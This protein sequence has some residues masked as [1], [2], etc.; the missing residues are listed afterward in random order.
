MS[1]RERFM[2]G[3]Y[4]SSSSFWL[5]WLHKKLLVYLSFLLVVFYFVPFFFRNTKFFTLAGTESLSHILA[6]EVGFF[7]YIYLLM[8]LIVALIKHTEA[9]IHGNVTISVRAIVKATMALWPQILV[10]SLLFAIVLCKARYLWM[11]SR[12]LP[13]TLMLCSHLLILIVFAAWMLATFLVLPVIAVEKSG[14]IAAIRKSMKLVSLVFVELI[15]A[16]CWIGI[17][18]GLGL[19]SILMIINAT[20]SQFI[21]LVLLIVAI[22]GHYLIH[23]ALGVTQALLYQRSIQLS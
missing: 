17:I 8:F 9:I 16:L 5:L 20:G 22:V 6:L 7:I 2:V 21:A 4:L 15:A 13:L 14:V 18:G 12:S 11:L 19:I 23:S 3:L 1:I 10:W